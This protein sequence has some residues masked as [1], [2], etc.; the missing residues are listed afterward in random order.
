M[1]RVLGK[2]AIACAAKFKLFMH[3]SSGNIIELEVATSKNLSPNGNGMVW[4]DVS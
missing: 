1:V 2:M 4:I 3:W